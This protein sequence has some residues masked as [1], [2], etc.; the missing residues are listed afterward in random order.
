MLYLVGEAPFDE[1]PHCDYLIAQDLYLPPF[2]VDAFLPAA[3]FAEADGTLTNLEGRVQELRPVERPRRAPVTTA[4]GPT[5]RS[6][7]ELAQRL[8]RAGL[9]YADAAA[10]RRAIRAEL[11][12]FPRERRPAAD[13]A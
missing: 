13:G 12:G 5:G 6:S 8:G 11:P 2:P 10:V 7:S 1:R 3:S 9:G 4:R